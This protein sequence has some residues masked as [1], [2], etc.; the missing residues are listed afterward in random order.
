MRGAL[1]DAGFAEP[2]A[3]CAAVNGAVQ[4]SIATCKEVTTVNRNLSPL[5]LR[6]CGNE[7]LT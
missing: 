3:D 4:D 2:I 5:R 6:I 1:R 7:L